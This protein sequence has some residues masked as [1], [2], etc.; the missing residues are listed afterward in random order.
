M[1]FKIIT[2]NREFESNGSEI[3]QEVAARL[4]LPYIDKFLITESAQKSGFS[5]DHIEAKDELLASRFEYS[6]T[7]A[8]HYYG[9]GETHLTTNEQVARVQF[10]IIRE[11]ASEGPCLIV[12]RCANYILREDPAVLDV[13]IHAGVDFR[14][15]NTV[16]RMGLSEKAARKEVRRTDRARKRYYTHFT[17]RDWNEPDSY[18]LVLNSERLGTEACVQAIIHAYHGD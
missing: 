16:R 15:E 17:G 10:D 1:A 18:H 4:H 5:V 8:A 2:V 6:Q 14:V 7:Q 13:F 11:L 9:G 3:A 12:G